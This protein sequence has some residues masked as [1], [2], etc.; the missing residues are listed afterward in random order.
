MATLLLSAA[1]GALGGAFGGP[2]GA[3][4]GRAA[5]AVIGG[6]L[7]QRLLG[8]GETVDGARM[9]ALRVMDS[10]EGAAIPRVYGRMRV[11]GQVIWA[12]R[13]TESASVSGGGKGAP[14][15]RS[16]SYAVSL[17]VAL[18][19]G[20]I[21]RIGRIWAD[22][23]PLP[24]D[25]ALI[26]LHRGTEDQ[27]PDPLIA[28]IEG[29]QGAPAYRGTAYVVFEAL[30]LERFGRRVPQIHVE[31][32]RQPRV[33][34]AL[35][36]EIAPPPSDLIRGV[37][38]SPGSGEFALDTIP[39]R[40]RLGPGR[41]VTE[42]VNS[43]AEIPDALAAL[44]QLQDELPFCG[45]TSLVVSWFGDDLRCG[46]C[47]IE[48]RVEDKAK[49]TEPV[50]W[51]VNGLDRSA[52]RAVGRRDGRPVYGGTP[53]DGGVVRLIREM[54]ER[55]L[56]VMFYPFILMDV[57]P[58]SALPDPYGG[59]AQQA[60]PWRG[61]ITLDVAPGRPGSPEGTS[62]ADAQVAA[63]FG[64]ARP[65]DFR[66]EGDAVRYR[67]REEWGLRRFIL[68]YAHLCAA[69]GGVDAFCIGSELRGLT[70]IR[71]Q[72]GAYPA[73]Q[74]LRALAADVR[75]I[76]GPAVRIGYAADWSEYF[77]HHPADGSGDAVFHLDPLWADPA[78][79]F[80][81]ID[82]YMPLSD[83]RD[84]ED[85]LD[86]AAGSPHSLAYLQAGVE[87]G[88]GFDWHYASE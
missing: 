51:S 2:L 69:A 31:V 64:T 65:E 41:T 59:A 58:D 88:E 11:A 40:R 66:R 5:G 14:R 1:G 18:C 56:A 85:H 52:A 35:S 43:P 57:A 20:P 86:A 29:E 80:V 37:A 55:G 15:V 70:W 3:I 47:R 48:P 63:F 42:N 25:A 84:G 46:R 30:D 60:Y 77:G 16:Y 71:G 53:A 62:E 21:E 75:A 72:G 74:A 68:H 79:D 49:L 34:R 78:I 73:V 4:A 23:A 45:A 33:D 19:E 61:R 36:P 27:T 81:G 22:G 38:L 82:N 28:A 8:G 13:F 67:G 10:R 44:D 32:F 6:V 83:W 24:S 76:L 17:A 50:S 54:R 7:D 9:D 39:V 26:R 12:S 87:G